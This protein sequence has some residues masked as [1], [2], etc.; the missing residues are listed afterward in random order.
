M[1]KDIY[2]LLKRSDIKLSKTN[3]RRNVNEDELNELAESIKRHG[4]LQPLIVRKIKDGYEVVAGERRYRAALKANLEVLPV[5]IRELTNEEVIEIQ[6]I[7]NLQ[8]KDVHPLDEAYGFHN[9]TNT[10]LNVNNYDVQKVGEIIGKS[11]AYV[12]SRLKLLDLTETLQKAFLENRIYLGH[13]LIIARLQPEDQEKA[14]EFISDFNM[15]YTDFGKQ[16]TK[17]PGSI[18]CLKGWVNNNILLDLR[19]APFNT[20]DESLNAV[21][22]IACTNCNRRTGFNKNLFPEIE[23]EDCCTYPECFAQKKQVSLE[24]CINKAGVGAIHVS[25]L[26]YWR[27]EEEKKLL[28]RDKYVII[29]KNNNCDYAVNAV[30]TA[31]GEDEQ[32]KI[33][34]ALIICANRNCDLHFPKEKINSKSQDMR[35]ATPDEKFWRKME[36][37]AGPERVEEVKLYSQICSRIAPETI[38]NSVDILVFICKK[39]YSTLNATQQ[40]IIIENHKIPKEEEFDINA[41]GIPEDKLCDKLIQATNNALGLLLEMA[42]LSKTTQNAEYVLRDEE[43]EAALEFCEY[44]NLVKNDTSGY[45]QVEAL[46]TNYNEQRVKAFDKFVLKQNRIPADKFIPDTIQDYNWTWIKERYTAKYSKPE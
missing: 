1:N 36:I 39:F 26:T 43:S 31:A 23:K 41:P 15:Q 24:R 8:R 45:K 25:T 29:G 10:S 32:N 18:K 34:K 40:N 5:L 27:N 9:L 42:I 4:I 28:A 38:A 35:T 16:K 17:E 6:I 11:E 14:L 21:N 37:I 46:R 12:Y 19:K 13:A 22:P 20:K 7:E 2:Q 30:I 33:G 44:H 3:P